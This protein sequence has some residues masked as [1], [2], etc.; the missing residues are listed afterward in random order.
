MKD[1]RSLLLVLLSTGLVAT[2]VY[3]FYDKSSY[4]QYKSAAI[5][6]DSTAIQDV[7][8]SLQKVYA[9]TI[10]SLDTRLDSSRNTT[11]SLQ[12]QLTRRISEINKLKSEISSIL[13][14][15]NS[16]SS[17]LKE[18]RLKMA[19]LEEKVEQLRNENTS[20]EA[21]KQSL[22]AKLDQVSGEVTSLEQNIRRLDDENKD[23][24]E[25]IKQASVFMASALHFTAMDVR[26]TKEQET[27]Q[28]KKADKFV[29]S[30]I[31]QN[32]LNQY[33]NAEVYLV[34]TEPDGHVLQNSA[35]DSGTFDT[36]AEGKK[37]FSRRIRFDYEKSEQKRLIFS[38]D[39][40]NFQKG[41]YTLQ[42]WH[43]GV[44]IGETSRILH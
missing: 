8:D 1:I 7:R 30:F 40:D 21:E 28:S 26:D 42:V 2:W 10:S 16:T 11:D 22:T 12:V 32:N 23:L 27:A 35:W 34:I 29:A 4:S 38:L 15:P 13:K 37:N 9:E 41:K 17:Q 44:L 33:M 39:T 36:K 25:K 31:L 6:N 19:E 24:K 20:K 3:H 18:A 14:N 43:Q 5:N